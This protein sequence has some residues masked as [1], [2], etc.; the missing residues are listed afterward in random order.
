[1]AGSWSGRGGQGL[2]RHSQ[3][4]VTITHEVY[5]GVKDAD[6]IY[7]DVWVSMGEEGRTKERLRLLSSYQVNPALMEATGKEGDRIPP[8][9]SCGKGRRLPMRS[10]KDPSQGYG[11]RRRTE[12]TIKAVMLATI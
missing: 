8:L 10:Q 5:Q 9:P 4:S 7:T 11:I 1:M 3:G 6:A 12:N 2:L